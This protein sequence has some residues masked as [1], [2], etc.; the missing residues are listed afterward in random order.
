MIGGGTAGITIA[1]RLA[2]DPTVSVAIIEAGGFYETDNGN[3]SVVPGLSLS[4]PVLATTAVYQQQPLVD[5][6]LVSVPQTRAANRR[7][8][9]AQGKTL[10][11]S[12][13]LNTMAYHRATSGTYQR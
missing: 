7:I 12:S 1:S 13:G 10:A 5:W 2:E 9:Y 4:S 8:H 3:R 6:S 11:G